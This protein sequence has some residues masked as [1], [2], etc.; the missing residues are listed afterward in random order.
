MTGLFKVETLG[1]TLFV[2]AKTSKEAWVKTKTYLLEVMGDED[3]VDNE[4]D[5]VTYE[6]LLES[7]TVK[8]VWQ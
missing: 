8:G 6:E 3:A 7:V 5:D 4:M 1:G 2:M